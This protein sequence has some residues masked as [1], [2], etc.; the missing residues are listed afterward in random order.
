MRGCGRA[1]ALIELRNLGRTYDLG[2]VQVHALRSVTLDIRAGE[3]L[4]LIGPSGSGK[5]TLMNTVGCLDRPTTGSYHLDGVDVGRLGVDALARLR[6]HQIGFVFQNF[7][8][9]PRTTA[10]ENVEVPMLYDPGTTRRTRRKRAKELLARVGLGDR[11][12]HKP[13]QLSGGQ[14]QRVAIARSLVNRPSIL[15]CDEP[16]GNLDTR[17]SREIMAFFRE[18]N[19]TEGLTVILVTHDV[20]VARQADRAVVLVD[21]EVVVDTPDIERAQAA[22]H[23]R[24]ALDAEE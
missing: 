20:E 2:E 19:R 15:L 22:L 3:F 18:L 4:A 16:T 1:M 21:G 5:S 12:D 7:N 11:L 14:Q 24:S 10:L 6:N 17:T 13:N 23:Q 9:L 8:L